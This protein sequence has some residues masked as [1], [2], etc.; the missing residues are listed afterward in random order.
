MSRVHFDTIQIDPANP[1]Q[2][3]YWAEQLQV[4]PSELKAA[5]ETAGRRVVNIRRSL[6]K[7]AYIVC[8]ADWRQVRQAKPQKWTAFPPV[9]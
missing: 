9:A 7:T 4:T 5:M 1:A 2:V 3:Q 6:G 8:L